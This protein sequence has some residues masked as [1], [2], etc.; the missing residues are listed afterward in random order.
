MP[1]IIS[2]RKGLN[3]SLKGSAEKVLSKIPISSDYAVKPG[4]FYG[5][6]PKLTVNEG[7]QVLA[8][9]PLFVDKNNP[10]IRFV[11][12]VSGTVSRILRGD[13]RKLLSVTVTPSGEQRHVQHAVADIK[14]L[15]RD[16]V[17][18]RML[19]SGA[20]PFLK[21]RPYGILANPADNPKAVFISGFDS[22]PLGPDIDFA[23]TGEGEA[24]QAGIDALRKL[25]D[26]IHLSL[27]NQVSANSIFR[28]IKGV[29][30]HTF[31]GPHP[32]G[33]VG[34]QIHHLSPINKGEIVW[35]IEPQHVVSLGRLFL[36]GVYDV[37]KVVA[38]V[39]SE[40]KK[41]RY[42][43]IISGASI[44]PLQSYID[45]SSNPRYISGNVLTGANIGAGGH[46]DFYSTMISVIPEGDYYEFLGWAN[47]LRMKKYSVSRSYLSWIFPDKEYALDT[48]VNGGQRAFVMTG[49][50]EKVLPMDIY[51]VHLLKAILS[52]DVDRME[53]LGIYEVIE[54][55]LALCEFVCTSKIDVQHILRR[56]IN[57]M[58]KE[59]GDA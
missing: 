30:T 28:K 11:S 2:I 18:Q 1:N 48:N 21:Q 7:D 31:V 9:A 33:N 3:I 58:I 36:K 47:P 40:V 19:E 29:K 27:N 46:L 17:V 25:S 22:A 35:A 55:D 37:S 12:P 16:D 6:M 34:I 26:T 8:G 44:A 51:P 43:R 42:F 15:S 45:T 56:G 13:K 41:P 49:E 14:A 23:L 5:L 52:E 32:A 57:L 50:Y 39:G 53:Q 54:E 4:D 59:M 10:G 24:F 38:L 20:W